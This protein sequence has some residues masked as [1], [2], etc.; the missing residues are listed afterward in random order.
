MLNG[1][2]GIYKFTDTVA[3]QGLIPLLNL[4]AMLS[5]NI[6]IMNL[7]PVPA[8]DGGRILFVLYEAIFRRPV[9]KRVEMI[10][11][12]AG[13]IFMF[14]VMIMVTWNDISRYFLK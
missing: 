4:A 5:I 11:V 10:I 12:G 14:F 2:V 7:I 3:Q 13:V 9:N 1:P 6:G 8:L